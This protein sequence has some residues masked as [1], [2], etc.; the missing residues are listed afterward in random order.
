MKAGHWI[1]ALAL[2]A[3]GGV[4][5]WNMAARQTESG[6]PGG[7]DGP[8]ADGAQPQ[9][10]A[11]P[12]DP[13]YQRS[14][15]G[16][17]P[18]GMDLVPVCAESGGAGADVSIDPRVVQNLGVRTEAVQQR[19]L[20][21]T[22]TAVGTVAYDETSFQMIHAR[23][24]G[25]LEGLSVES[26]GAMVAAGQR[27]YALFSPKLIAAEQEY[28]SAL[29]AGRRALEQAAGQRLAALGYS[30]AQ[31]QALRRRETPAEQLVRKAETD[32]VVTMLGVRDGQFVSPGT[33]IMTLASLKSVWVEVDVLERDAAAIVV[34]APAR[35]R[36]EAWPGRV[37]QGRVEHIDPSL[38]PHTRSLTVRLVFDNVDGALRP[39]MFARAAIEGGT[40]QQVLSLPRAALIR[41]GRDTRVVRRVGPGQYDVVAVQTGLRAG[42]Y[43]QVL[44][45]VQAG[46]EVVVAGQFLLDSEANLDA[47]SLRQRAVQSA[48]H[49]HASVNSQPDDA[50]HMRHEHGAHAQPESTSADAW[51]RGRVVAVDVAARRITLKH[52][53]IESVGMAA[54]TMPFKAIDAIDLPAFKPGDDVRFALS[55]E[56][57]AIVQLERVQ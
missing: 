35:V 28:L 20:V 51:T 46:D 23:A 9:H 6:A 42:A 45:G 7:V 26:G 31:I 19:D 38:D 36:V 4:A 27:L 22:I 49:N 53:R 52:E 48:A 34:G 37:W 5:G 1:A 30:N 47:E 25:W 44:T 50:S 17:S 13:N 15:P 43:M 41:N 14:A 56:T 2:L 3:L 8:C 12:M 57:M 39:N 29:G 55:P 33:H 10:W 21:R 32:G 18:M 54:M 40:R 16:K 24:E 11:A